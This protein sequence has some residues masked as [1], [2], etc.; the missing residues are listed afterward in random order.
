MCPRNTCGEIFSIYL[1]MFLTMFIVQA[2]IKNVGDFILWQLLGKLVS[3]SHLLCHLL[4]KK[5]CHET[6]Y[7]REVLEL[8]L[9]FPRFVEPG[10]LTFGK[11]ALVVFFP[12]AGKTAAAIDTAIDKFQFEAGQGCNLLLNLE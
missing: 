12:G 11:W 4:I 2:S 6:W 1:D 3:I 9:G 8:F 10:L 5:E 7:D